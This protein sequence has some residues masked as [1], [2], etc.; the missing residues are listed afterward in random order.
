MKKFVQKLKKFELNS[1]NF[2]LKHAKTSDQSVNYGLKVKIT[3]IRFL[4]DS[5]LSGDLHFVKKGSH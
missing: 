1:T 3:T 5:G 2:K 4:L